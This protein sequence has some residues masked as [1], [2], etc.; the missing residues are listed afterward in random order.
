M[1]EIYDI[2]EMEAE[3]LLSKDESH[4]LDFKSKLASGTNLQRLLS[5][6]ANTDGGEIYLGVEDK[7]TT[8]YTSLLDL[9][10]G[11]TDQEEANAHVQ[12]E[13]V[14]INPTL[15]DCTYEFFSIKGRPEK[16]LILRILV[17]KSPHVHYTSDKKVGNYKTKATY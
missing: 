2:D 9:W 16:G 3:A 1:F 11:Y 17:E 13:A 8:P 4:F 14:H 12:N 5:A 6:F 15:P 10:N 7:K